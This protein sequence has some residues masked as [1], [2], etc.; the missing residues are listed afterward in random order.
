[1]QAGTAEQRQLIREVI[2][3]GGLDRI[4]EVHA[5][6]ENTGAISYTR[7]LA[8]QEADRAIASLRCIPDSAHKAALL[9]LANFAVER[10][11]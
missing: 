7:R 4:A 6:V 1:M 9:A 2:E 11:S 8:R 3:Q 10:Q 5:A